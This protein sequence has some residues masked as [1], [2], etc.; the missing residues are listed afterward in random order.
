MYCYKTL[1]NSCWNWRNLTFYVIIHV[2]HFDHWPALFSC[3]TVSIFLFN[4]SL[5]SQDCAKNLFFCGTWPKRFAWH[6]SCALWR[7]I[8][9]DV[10]IT[11]LIVNVRTRNRTG[12]KFNFIVLFNKQALVFL[13]FKHPSKLKWNKIV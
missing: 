2:F 12:T 10:A 3:H 9:N 8:L 13:V 7:H 5:I 6:K 11:Y 4:S 1:K